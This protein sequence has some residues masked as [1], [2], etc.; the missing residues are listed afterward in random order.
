MMDRIS[1]EIELCIIMMLSFHGD[2]ISSPSHLI[3]DT[4]RSWCYNK[5]MRWTESFTNQHK[6]AYVFWRVRC[7]GR[8]LFWLQTGSIIVYNICASSCDRRRHQ[9]LSHQI[10]RHNTAPSIAPFIYTHLQK[11]IHTSTDHPSKVVRNQQ[12]KGSAPQRLYFIPHLE[13]RIQLISKKALFRIA[14]TQTIHHRL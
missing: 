6:S 1:F 3:V 8:S 9:S 7:G 12:L 2:K 11:G 4:T 10:S 13:N 5:E 14:S